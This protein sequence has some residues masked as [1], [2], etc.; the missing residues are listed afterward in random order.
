MTFVNSLTKEKLLLSIHPVHC[1]LTWIWWSEW[2]NR[3]VVQCGEVFNFKAKNKWRWLWMETVVEEELFAI[4]IWK[5]NVIGTAFCELCHCAIIY[6]MRGRVTIED[7]MKTAR[8]QKW[9][10]ARRENVRFLILT[11]VVGKCFEIFFYLWMQIEGTKVIF[12]MN[13]SVIDFKFASR[14]PQIA[15]N[16]VST[17]NFSR[18]GEWGGR[19]HALDLPRNF[20]FSFN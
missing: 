13:F 18:R 6:N 17:S 20:L 10:E 5:V 16:L 15:Q 4:H 1:G 3:R 9:Q 11:I 14:I 7:H 2:G 19:G 8:N 12:I